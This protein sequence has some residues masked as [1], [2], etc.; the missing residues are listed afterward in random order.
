MEKLQIKSDNPH[1]PW[2]ALSATGSVTAG[3]CTCMAR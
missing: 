2:I 3:Y 1:V